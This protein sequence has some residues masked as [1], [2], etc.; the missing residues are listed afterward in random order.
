MT[1][2]HRYFIVGIRPVR[3]RALPDGGLSCESFDWSTGQ[4]TLDNSYLAK[5][6]TGY[7]DEVDE[8]SEADFEA[9][10]KRLRKERNLPAG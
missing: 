1:R 4:F 9:A 5:V 6:T 10:V 7:G 2:R 3:L 8:I